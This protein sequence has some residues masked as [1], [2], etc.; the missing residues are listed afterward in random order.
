VCLASPLDTPQP[1]PQT[2]AS[3]IAL[4]GVIKDVLKRVEQSAAINHQKNEGAKA[5]MMLFR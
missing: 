1:P 2:S 5:S 3:A 4:A